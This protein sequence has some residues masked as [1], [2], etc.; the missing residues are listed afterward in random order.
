V[1]GGFL[2]FA[3]VEFDQ[4]VLGF[5]PTSD[6]SGCHPSY[7]GACV[8]LASDVDCYGG[9]GNGPSFVGRVM[10]VGPDVYGLD[11]DGDGVGCD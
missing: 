7:R 10:V 5:L 9:G 2:V 6:A 8:P 3:Y 4:R 1:I 11:R